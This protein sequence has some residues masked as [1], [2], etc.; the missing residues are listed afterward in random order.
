[1]PAFGAPCT[2]MTG[3]ALPLLLES[4]KDT[5]V[6]FMYDASDGSYDHVMPPIVNTSQ[7]SADALTGDGLCGT[8]PSRLGGYVARCGHGPRLPF[9]VMSPWSRVNF[10]DHK[11]TARPE[12]VS[13]SRDGRSDRVR[14]RRRVKLTESRDALGPVVGPIAREVVPRYRGAYWQRP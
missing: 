2:C 1:M 14:R 13:R 5:A 6:I 11:Q 7:S 10:V 12:C 8:R 4:W 9:V 3:V